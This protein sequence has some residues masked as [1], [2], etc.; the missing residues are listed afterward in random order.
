MPTPTYIP[1][2]TLNLSTSTSEIVFSSI[3]ATYRDLIVVFTGT[4]TISDNQRARFNGNT[5]SNY[6]VVFAR[7]NGSTATSSS[8]TDTQFTFGEIDSSVVCTNIMQI[9]DYAQTDKHKTILQRSN[10][11]TN[12]VFMYAGRWALTDAI[13]TISI[14]PASGSYNIG[15][16]C[17][18]YGIA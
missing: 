7:G 3:P 10:D 13:N 14:Y 16:T 6:S 18:L 5:G 8:S 1:L 17:S 12:S 4:G 11:T 15:A 2:A 9:F